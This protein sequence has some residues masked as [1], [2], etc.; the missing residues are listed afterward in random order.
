MKKA[1]QNVQLI[2]SK[3]QPPNLKKLLTR[4]KFVEDTDDNDLHEEKDKKCN[5]RKCGTCELIGNCSEVKLNNIKAPFKIKAKMDCD[6]EDIIYLL[7]CGGCHKQ[8]IGETGELRARVRIHK[9]QIRDPNLQTLYVSHHIAH[10][11][12]GKKKL[13]EIILF[14]FVNHGDRLYREEVEQYFIDKFKPELNR[15]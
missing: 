11:T 7:N 13:F 1:I 6:A 8:Y 9:Q 10:C 12:V 3:R 15:S 14:Y 5:R 4:A 2:N